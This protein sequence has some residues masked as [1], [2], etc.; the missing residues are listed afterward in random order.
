MNYLLDT[1]VCVVLLRTGGAGTVASR[2]RAVDQTEVAICSIVL[3]ELLFGALRSQKVT[4]NLAEVRQLAR[5]FAS[6]PFDDAA[7][8]KHAEIRAQLAGAGKPIGPLDMMIA[9]IALAQDL[10]L[11]T[12]NVS[13]FSR[14]PGLREK[15]G[16]RLSNYAAPA[17]ARGASTAPNPVYSSTR[18]MMSSVGPRS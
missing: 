17:S 7:A 9:A 18:F 8:E 6:F 4:A 1:N 11:V 12:H 13:E 15:T 2:L 10:T 5:G 3:T 14:I 16:R